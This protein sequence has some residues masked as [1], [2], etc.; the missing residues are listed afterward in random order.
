VSTFTDPQHELSAQRVAELLADGGAQVIDVR[1][2]YEREAGRIP[3]TRHIE[4]ERLASQA[5]TI[6][7]ETPVVFYCRLG[8]RSGMAAQAF[9]TAGYEAFNLTGGITAWRDAGL[10][11]EPE[12]GRVAEH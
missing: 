8:A 1:E 10:P 9:R 3:G 12:G 7:R 4:L 5:E 2:P 6:P 11:L